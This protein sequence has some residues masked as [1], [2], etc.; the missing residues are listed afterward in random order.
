MP[1]ARAGPRQDEAPS[2]PKDF[3]GDRPGAERPRAFGARRISKATVPRAARHVPGAS[4][5]CVVRTLRRGEIPFGR[6]NSRRA[7]R[8]P[9]RCSRLLHPSDTKALHA[10]RFGVQ[11]RRLRDRR[12]PKAFPR[13]FKG[14][15]Q[16]GRNG[17]A[18]WVSG[19]IGVA[20]SKTLMPRAR[21]GPRQDEAP[22]GPK[23]FKGA[24]HTRPQSKAPA[25]S[26]AGASHSNRLPKAPYLDRSS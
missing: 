25:G 16:C 10:P 15:L 7:P 12:A 26:S 13:H 9:V 23:G 5:F 8:R 24:R 19:A 2:G 3:K 17:A 11:P 4:E 22:S 21:A 1:R 6:L 18:V 14:A 20:R